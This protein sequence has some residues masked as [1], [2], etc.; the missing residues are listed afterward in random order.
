MGCRVRA[1]RGACQPRSLGSLLRAPPAHLAER[2]Q[3]GLEHW[4]GVGRH[5]LALL[6][7]RLQHL[8]QR[9]PAGGREGGAGAWAAAGGRRILAMHLLGGRSVDR[10]GGLAAPLT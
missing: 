10:P 8:V 7:E 3:Q 2:R 6:A 9:P 1:S 4:P 5:Q